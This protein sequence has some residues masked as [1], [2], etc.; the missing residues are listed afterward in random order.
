MAILTD[1]TVH[2]AVLPDSS[3]LSSQDEGPLRIKTFQLGPTA[4]VL[5]QP[6]VVSALWHPLGHMGACLVTVT[7]DACVR[8]WEL[9]RDDRH[10]FNEPAL[11]LDLKKL[12]NAASADQDFRASKYGTTK[13]FTP[14]SVEMEV[15]AACFGG[16]G[17]AEEHGWSSMTLWLAM[18]EGDVYALCPLLPTKWEPTPTTIPSLSTSV[19]SKAAMAAHDPSVSEEERRITDQQQA[20]LADIDSQDPITTLHPHTLRDFDVYFRPTNPPAIPKL[21]GPFR[22]GPEP[23]Y[24]DVTDIFVV[25]PRVDDDAMMQAEDDADFFDRE[26]LSVGIICLANKA[27]DV[28][29]SLALDAVEAQWLPSKRVSL[30]S[31]SLTSQSLLTHS[32]QTRQQRKYELDV[33]TSELVLLE[34]VRTSAQDTASWPTFSQDPTNRYG[35]FLTLA[36]GIYSL[37]L[38]PWVSSLEDELVS[39][40]DSGVA[41]RLDVLLDSERSA[42]GK[43]LHLETQSHH[44]PACVNLVDPDLGWFVLTSASAQPQAIILD[45]PLDNDLYSPFAPDAPLAL[46]A[47][48]TRQ[49]YQPAEAFFTT[50][51]LPAFLDSVTQSTNSRLKKTDLKSQVRFSPATLHLMT[52]AHRLLSSETSRLGAAA[53]DLFRRCERMKLELGEQIR[54]VDEIAKRIEAVTGDD[55]EGAGDENTERV[56]GTERIEQ[57]MGAARDRSEMLQTRIE[58]LRRKMAGLGGKELSAREEA[59]SAEVVSLQKSI[60]FEECASEEM[61]INGEH[62]VSLTSRFQAITQLQK[63]LVIRAKELSEKQTGKENSG[64]QALDAE[65]SRIPADFRRQKIQ[66]VMQLLERETALVDAVTERLGKLQGLES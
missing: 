32:S 64:E 44:T 10:S 27:G 4:H 35:F 24:S 62:D 20:W 58:S 55:D 1:H 5:E 51:Q 12:G 39:A 40:T 16:A 31:S 15:A 28:H 29:I 19:V 36:H 8:L 23:D 57:R 54:Q 60:G 53:A 18:V 34:T 30:R 43:I 66:Q 6:P 14:D 22:L 46:P 59:W 63:D 3:H 25:A 33:C 41:F 65:V 7:V 13:A 52:E 11:A 42:V 21:Q 56:V 26:G 49:S 50:S 9:N 2:V 47:P 61:A 45:L 17:T 48:E 37:S 38:S